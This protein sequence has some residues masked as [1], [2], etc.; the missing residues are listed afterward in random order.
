MEIGKNG[1]RLKSTWSRYEPI[2]NS[3]KNSTPLNSTV[4]LKENWRK[5]IKNSRITSI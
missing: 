1:S 3:K 4:F 2:L 5:T